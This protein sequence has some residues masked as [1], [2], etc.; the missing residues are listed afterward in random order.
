MKGLGSVYY[1]TNGWSTT[2]GLGICVAGERELDG[3]DVASPEWEY[4][5]SPFDRMKR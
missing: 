5:T 3:I 1:A 4:W 2:A